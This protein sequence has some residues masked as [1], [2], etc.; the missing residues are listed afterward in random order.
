[1]PAFLTSHSLF[2]RLKAGPHMGPPAAQELPCILS[3]SVG[4]I[5]WLISWVL[6]MLPGT[7]L[8]ASHTLSL[9]ILSIEI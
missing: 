8:S 5:L 4:P 3:T 7:V 6:T 1:M 2:L 9:L